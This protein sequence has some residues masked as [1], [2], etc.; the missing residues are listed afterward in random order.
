MRAMLHD[1]ALM[2]YTYLRSILDS[3]EPVC[4]NQSRAVL[5]ET[6]QSLLYELFALAV[7]E[8]KSPSSRMSIGGFCLY[9]REPQITDAEWEGGVELKVKG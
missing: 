6:F 2:H 7:R 9:P 5:H 8:P 1:F 3:R 4:D